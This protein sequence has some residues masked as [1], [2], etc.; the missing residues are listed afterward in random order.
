[1]KKILLTVLV[2]GSMSYS[3]AGYNM[4]VCKGC[5]GQNFELKAMGQSKVVKDMSKDEIVTALKGYKDGSYGRN[6]AATMKGQVMNLTDEDIDA[7]A[8]E[9]KQ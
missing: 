7:L 6:L 1:M 3:F 9:I 5:H 8:N 2:I 4:P